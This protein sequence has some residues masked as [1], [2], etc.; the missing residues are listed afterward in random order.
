MLFNDYIF[1]LEK[2]KVALRPKLFQDKGHV[3]KNIY[4]DK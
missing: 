2:N 1:N 3:K 4:V